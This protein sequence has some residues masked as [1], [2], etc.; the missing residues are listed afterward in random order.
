M[1]S[2]TTWRA[3]VLPATGRGDVTGGYMPSKWSAVV[4]GI[5]GG[6]QSSGLSKAC[7]DLLGTAS[8]PGSEGGR[9]RRLRGT[10]EPWEAQ[11]GPSCRWKG[12]TRQRGA[13]VGWVEGVACRGIGAQRYVPCTFPSARQTCHPPTD[14]Q[15]VP[16]YV[17]VCVCE[18]VVYK[19]IVVLRYAAYILSHVLL[20]LKACSTPF[21]SWR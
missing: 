1:K 18:R 14:P 11:P 17:C 16:P 21:A 7:S 3:W 20:Q 2:W 15:T 5:P 12:R 9:E 19:I 13:A 10:L 6:V 8:S 4:S